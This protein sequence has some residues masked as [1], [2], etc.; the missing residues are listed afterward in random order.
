MNTWKLTIKPDNSKG[1]DAFKIC[2]DKSLLGLGWSE[3]YT[4]KQA[5]NIDEAKRLVKEKFGKWPYALKYLLEELKEGDHVWIHQ[6]GKYYLC[7]AKDE[8]FFGKSI[9]D[10]FL[11]YDLGHA[12]KAKW[13][14]EGIPEEYV[15]GT[16]QRGTIAQ[17][18]IQKISIS[19]KEQEV[20]NKIFNEL[21]RNPKWQPVIDEDELSRRISKI[22]VDDLFSLMSPKDDFEDVISA[23]LQSQGWVLIKSTCFRSKPKFEFSML[24]KDNKVCRVQVKSGKHPNCLRPSDYSQFVSNKN[25]IFLFSTHKNP[26]PGE[27]IN[28]IYTITHNEVFDWATKNVWSLTMPLKLRLWIFLNEING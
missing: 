7:K 19:E 26:Y 14:E 20:H 12:R 1:Y 9:D 25:I 2:K 13:I 27:S 23:Y 16:I 4:E 5:S 10:D 24:N 6:K 21:S 3:A 17:R 11:N 15:S 18:M 28:G 22:Q 8:I